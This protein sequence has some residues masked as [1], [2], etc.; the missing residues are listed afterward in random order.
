MN[1]LFTIVALPQEYDD[2]VLR[3][4]VVFIPRNISPLNDLTAWGFPG[5]GPFAEAADRFKLEAK[6]IAGLNAL[7]EDAD[8]NYRELLDVAI[9][10]TAKPIY[11]AMHAQFEQVDDMPSVDQEPPPVQA[12]KFIKKYLPFSYRRSFNFTNPRTDDAVI[13]DSYHCAF[14]SQGSDSAFTQT[15]DHISWGKVYAHCLR[16]PGLAAKAGLIF[17]D[18]TITVPNSQ[19]PSVRLALFGTVMVRSVKIR[20]ALAASPGCLKQCA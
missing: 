9:P 20:P 16:H 17:T 18:L 6:L 8:V 19:P 5:I 15:S 10:E 4:N 2:G 13:D 12:T 7:P 1:S 11:E 3:F 14:K